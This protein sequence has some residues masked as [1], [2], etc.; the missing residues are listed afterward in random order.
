VLFALGGGDQD[1]SNLGL[2][3]ATSVRD[4]IFCQQYNDLKGHSKGQAPRDLEMTIEIANGMP[5]NGED[6]DST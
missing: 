2:P 5:S 3:S 6:P 1:L 4:G